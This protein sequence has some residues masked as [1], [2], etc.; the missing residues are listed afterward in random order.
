MSNV[1][2]FNG[3][4]VEVNGQAMMS[5]KDLC[6][7]LNETR[8]EGQSDVTHTNVVRDIRNM[9]ENLD[10]SSL[11]NQYST[12]LDNRG[13]VSE[14]LL[15]ED[16]SLCYVTSK[17]SK[18]RLAVVKVFNQIKN[19]KKETAPSFNL[20]SNFKE[21]LIMLVAAEDEKERL[22]LVATEAKNNLE[23]LEKSHVEMS[24]TAAMKEVG[25]RPNLTMAFMR[26]KGFFNLN[27]QPTAAL[28]G[29]GL[30]EVCSVKVND[31][32]YEQQTRVTGKG[33]AW[34]DQI[35]RKSLPEDCFEAGKFERA[36][37]RKKDAKV[38][39]KETYE[40]KN[41]DVRVCL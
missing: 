17:R 9:L 6:Q 16:L 14:F 18:V 15:N 5:S 11:M 28:C 2:V 41:G 40:S 10:E 27:N 12:K 4:L 36:A 35:L 19:A 25:F 29:K 37:Q 33:L 20:P 3:S 31:S 7:L 1:E 13:Y 22:Q 23:S 30:F 8:E 32:R 39:A 34:L 24:I 38:S 21:A 26:K